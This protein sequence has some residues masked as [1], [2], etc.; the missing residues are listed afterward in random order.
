MRV[1]FYLNVENETKINPEIKQEKNITANKE[2]LI[3]NNVE[4]KSIDIK[5]ENENNQKLTTPNESMGVKIELD[6]DD[7]DML[8]LPDESDEESD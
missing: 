1:N 8:E 6:N 2:T 3:E 5:T 4:N 7:E